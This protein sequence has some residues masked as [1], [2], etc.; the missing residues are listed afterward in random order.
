[1]P[2]L[3]HWLRYTIFLMKNTTPFLHVEGPSEI[4]EQLIWQMEKL[5]ARDKKGHIQGHDSESDG[6]RAGRKCV[7]LQAASSPPAHLQFAALF[8]SQHFSF[9][10]TNFFPLLLGGMLGFPSL[11]KSPPTLCCSPKFLMRPLACL[12]PR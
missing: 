8:A 10:L 2:A 5:R 11:F 1:M 4:I 3:Y 6:S 12:L 9:C 7:D